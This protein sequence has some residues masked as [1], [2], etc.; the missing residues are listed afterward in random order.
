ML[1]SKILNNNVV[2]AHN[3]KDIECV[4]MGSGIAFGKRVGDTIDSKKVQKIFE[5]KQKGVADKFSQLVQNIPL[6]YVKVCDEI[7]NMANRRVS[8]PLNESIYIA[9]TDHIVY[10]IKR[11]K[12]GIVVKN[13]VLWEMKKFYPD[14]YNMGLEAL[15]IIQK[16]LDV[17]LPED[18]AAFIALHIINAS[19]DYEDLLITKSTR[20]IQE[21]INFI[22][23][24][25]KI[26][27][28]EN[29]IHYYRFL[30]HIKYFSQRLVMK[31][32]Y[33]K[34][35]NE[36]F[37]IFKVKYPEVYECVEKISSMVEKNYDYKICNEEKAYLII[38]IRMILEK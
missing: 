16:R 32:K 24:Y 14:E 27:F 23:Y 12:E 5:V 31:E 29:S 1:I 21:I 4:V 36:I 38:H 9:L 3:S 19:S 26:E 33:D 10:S 30:T 18:E 34:K 13:S 28:D 20:I 8:K 6:E 37:E 2:I 17:A 35:D 15:N 25:F 7:I 11:Q 22:K